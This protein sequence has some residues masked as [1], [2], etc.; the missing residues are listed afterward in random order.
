M[1]GGGFCNVFRK[2]KPF[3]FGISRSRNKSSMSFRASILRALCLIRRWKNPTVQTTSGLALA[4]VDIEQTLGKSAQKQHGQQEGQS[5][6]ECIHIKY[7]HLSPGNLG[8][9]RNSCFFFRSLLLFG[10]CNKET[11]KKIPAYERRIHIEKI[12]PCPIGGRAGKF[13]HAGDSIRSWASPWKSP[14]G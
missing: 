14:T 10:Q 7:S 1:T 13:D 9:R 6:S 8:G 3:S 5:R 4:P 2:E 12:L 11:I